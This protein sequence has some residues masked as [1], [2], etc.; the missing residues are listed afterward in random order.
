[1]KKVVLAFFVSLL[2]FSCGEP[3]A[4]NMTQK[5]FQEAYREDVA[6]IVKEQMRKALSEGLKGEINKEDIKT[7]GREE[8]TE[9]IEDL[10]GL[11]FEE[12]ELVNKNWEEIKALKPKG[13]KDMTVKEIL[14][15]N[16]E[17][18]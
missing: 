10:T 17:E 6:K 18:K 7:D 3:E 13:Y 14:N 12:L 2:F 1:M 16:K 5:E 11:T 15:Y 9:R 8:L 4:Y